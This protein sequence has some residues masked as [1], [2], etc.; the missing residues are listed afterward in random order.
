[1]ILI[2]QVKKLEK[3]DTALSLECLPKMVEKYW[4]DEELKEEKEFQLNQNV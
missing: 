3:E 1:L 4:L 2:N